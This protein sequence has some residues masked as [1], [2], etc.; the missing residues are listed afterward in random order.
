MGD[1]EVKKKSSLGHVH[2][3]VGHLS[4]DFALFPA[5]ILNILF[6]PTQ[7]SS[8]IIH[9]N[10]DSLFHALKF[11]SEMFTLSFMISLAAGQ[12]KLFEGNSEWRGLLYLALQV[13]IATPIIYILCR[14]LPEKIPFS[15]MM[16][17]I[18]YV[19]GAFILILAAVSIPISYLDFTL[20]IPS[21]NRELDIFATEYERCLADHSILYR[22]M[23]GELQFFLYI[24]RWKPQDWANWFFDNYHFVLVLPFMPVFAFM[25]RPKRKVSFVLIC[26]FTA[27][28]YTAAVEGSD[29]I[30]RQAGRTLAVNDTEC[31]FGFLDQ[32]VSKYAPSLIA[33]QIAYKINNDS[34]K[35]HQYLAVTSVVSTGFL[36]TLKLKPN[37]EPTWQVLAQTPL[38]ARQSYCSNYLYWVA[39]RRI[40]ANILVVVND[41]ND[42]EV[43]RQVFTP[44][45]CPAWP[46]SGAAR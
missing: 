14:A 8:K 24:D 10:P 46:A 25:M 17:A 26:L 6:R 20:H 40:N 9:N 13:I 45:D 2:R 4:R 35:A 21:A 18:F 5:L 28:A 7:T 33:R 41:G 16:Q 39:A 36:V 42:A 12:F 30:R 29:F 37:I 3:V 44:R 1:A 43:L 34:L 23:R 27:V 15:N 11:Y 31:T 19:D 38:W 32:V 22:L